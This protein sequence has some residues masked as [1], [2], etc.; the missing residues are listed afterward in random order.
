MMHVSPETVTGRWHILLAEPQ[1][2]TTAAAGLAGRRFQAYLPTHTKERR[3]GRQRKRVTV[4]MPLMPGYVFVRVDP[5]GGL[6]DRVR[7]IP[8]IRDFLVVDGRKATLSEA[9][10]QLLVQIEEKENAPRATT[11]G[12]TDWGFN[13]GDAVRVGREGGVYSGMEGIFQRIDKSD[14]AI[15]HIVLPSRVWPVITSAAWIEKAS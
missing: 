7:T 2:E 5:L 9:A 12:R 14:R 11:A 13:A 4:T 6:W 8:G 1:R 15:L 3:Q 10:M